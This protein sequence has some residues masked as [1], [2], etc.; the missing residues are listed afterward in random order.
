M[1]AN[2]DVCQFYGVKS[3]QDYSA[4]ILWTLLVNTC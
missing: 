3:T 4:L 2:I 1:Y